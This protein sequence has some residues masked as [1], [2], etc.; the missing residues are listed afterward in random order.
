VVQAVKALNAAEMFGRDSEL[1]FQ[2]DQRSQR[3]L[4]RVVDRAS[5]EVILQV[6]PETVLRLAEHF[7]EE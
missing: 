4:L 1:K 2:L 7:K 5:G 6:P 3:M